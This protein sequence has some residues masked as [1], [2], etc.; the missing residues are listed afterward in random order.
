MKTRLFVFMMLMLLWMPAGTA[1]ALYFSDT[2]SHYVWFD[3]TMPA[4]TWTFDLDADVLD[5]GDINPADTIH[6]AYLIF[7]TFDNFDGVRFNHPEYTNIYLDLTPLIQ[8]WEVDPGY[9]WAGSVISAVVDDHLLEVT[10]NR[11][12]GDFGVS[13]MT[14]FGDYTDNPEGAA[15]VPE[16][17]TLFLLGGGLLGLAGVTRRWKPAR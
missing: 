6:S 1:S 13:W 4:Y 12:Y 3:R 8:G 11:T 16:P 14:V 9:W 5:W 17:A 15:P 2:Q 10:F 7:E